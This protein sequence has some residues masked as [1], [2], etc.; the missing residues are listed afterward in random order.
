MLSELLIRRTADMNKFIA[1]IVVIVFSFIAWGFSQ[2][3]ALALAFPFNVCNSV[4]S[5]GTI[6]IYYTTSSGSF[7]QTNLTKGSCR[8]FPALTNI[9]I[10]GG[11]QSYKI[12]PFGGRYGSCKNSYPYNA[13]PTK[14]FYFK[15][16]V[17]P[18]CK[19]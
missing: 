16:W 17:K 3:K 2:P 19:S 11:F 6:S 14:D 9:S 12:K 15:T 5:S 10:N 1:L 13:S 7:S 4:N 8:T 18:D